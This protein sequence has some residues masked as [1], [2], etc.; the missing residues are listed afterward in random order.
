MRLTI[1]SAR[2][3]VESLIPPILPTSA[4]ASLSSRVFNSRR[5][6]RRVLQSLPTS[7]SRSVVAT[8]PKIP[9]K[10]TVYHPGQRKDS[11]RLDLDRPDPRT[12]ASYHL[13]ER[14]SPWVFWRGTSWPWICRLPHQQQST[15]RCSSS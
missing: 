15:G 4:V 12:D 1:S 6:F 10:P 13:R 7:L 11:W 14:Y 2:S 3:D 5:S 9:S 8:S